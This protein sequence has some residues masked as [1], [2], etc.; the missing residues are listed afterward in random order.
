MIDKRF[1]VEDT[2]WVQHARLSSQACFVAYHPE[3]PT[4]IDEVSKHGYVEWHLTTYND[5]YEKWGIDF[6]T[7]VPPY[8]H[9]LMVYVNE[10]GVCGTEVV[11]SDDAE[12]DS[13]NN[14]D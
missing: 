14:A 6:I 5:L 7:L 2:F 9:L 8:P 11:R 4:T 1:G 13:S 10:H 12:D 3:Q